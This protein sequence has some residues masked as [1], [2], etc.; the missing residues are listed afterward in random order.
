MTARAP[1][2][3]ILLLALA[4][5]PFIARAQFAPYFFDSTDQLFCT[6]NNGSITVVT[7]VGGSPTAVVPPTINGLPVTSIVGNTELFWSSGGYSTLY[8]TNLTELVIPASVTS[9]GGLG[10]FYTLTN[11]TVNP[12]NTNFSSSGGM[13]FDQAGATLLQCPRALTGSYPVPNGVVSIAGSAFYQSAL[14]G[15]TFPASLK[16][17]GLEAFYWSDLTA[18]TI[19]STVTN[20][21][22]YTFSICLDLTNVTFLN[23]VTTIAPGMFSDCTNLTTVAIP[24]SV[25]NIGNYA[26]EYCSSLGKVVIGYGATV[27]GSSTF[28]SCVNLTNVSIPGS[29]ISIGPDAFNHCT[30]LAGMTIPDSVTDIGDDAFYYCTNLTS[31]TVSAGLTNIDGYAFDSCSNLVAAY[32]KGNA[33]AVGSTVFDNDPDAIAYYLPGT[34]GWSNSMSDVPAILW[35]PTFKA[36]GIHSNQFSALITASTNIPIVVEAST[37]LPAGSWI[38]LLNCTVTNGSIPFND[39]AWP[40]NTTRYYRIRSP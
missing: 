5:M 1:I 16:N 10:N 14:N 39:P 26:F 31:V 35:N 12:L 19:P 33:P 9:I 29:V 34:T 15:V 28:V 22:N 38:A 27:I 18:V 30:S 11:I 8:N 7:C 23:G 37:N 2:K 36:A 6:T 40:S 4:I 17:I 32:F 24:P 25:T 20:F 21:G 3:L 13:L